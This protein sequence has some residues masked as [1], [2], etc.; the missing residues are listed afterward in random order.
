MA[1]SWKKA[2]TWGWVI[3]NSLARLN[4]SEAEALISGVFTDRL[5]LAGLKQLELGV[6]EQ[7]SKFKPHKNS[8][9]YSSPT[10]YLSGL[11]SITAH[12]AMYLGMLRDFNYLALGGLKSIDASVAAELA[13]FSGS[14]DLN[15]LKSICDDTAKELSKLGSSC[16]NASD[17]TDNWW[18]EL[19]GL[20]EL[21]DQAAEHLSGFKGKSLVMS[22][23]TKLSGP[24]TQALAKYDGRFGLPKELYDRVTKLRKV[25]SNAL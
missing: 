3:F 21:S 12:D 10:L 17:P 18:L 25:G 19:N 23:L 8:L 9:G 5:S 11:E 13:K 14:L 7:L 15:G 2:R 4:A 6:A 20:T 22:G 24:A 1:D 16:R